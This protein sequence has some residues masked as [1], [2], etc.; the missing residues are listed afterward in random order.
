MRVPWQD[1]DD[2]VR[3]TYL[4]ARAYTGAVAWEAKRLKSLL[5]QLSTNV[6]HISLIRDL[7]A[8]YG[9]LTS[10]FSNYLSSLVLHIFR[11]RG[12]TELRDYI[13]G[14]LGMM[15][16][17]ATAGITPDYSVD[18]RLIFSDAVAKLIC[19]TRSLQHIWRSREFR[20]DTALP[21]WV[22]DWSA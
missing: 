21:S 7:I 18:H 9:M 15:P 11:H 5:I 6:S 8:A 20:R 14:I 3:A 17:Y 22:S 19:N 10:Y 2:A 13:F 12:A 4:S 1:F 16:E